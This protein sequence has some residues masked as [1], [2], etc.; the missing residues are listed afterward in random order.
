MKT[1]LL[2][3]LLGYLKVGQPVSFHALSAVRYHSLWGLWRPK[4]LRVAGNIIRKV[5][6]TVPGNYH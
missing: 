4:T 6:Y 5:M 3:V 1:G 2:C